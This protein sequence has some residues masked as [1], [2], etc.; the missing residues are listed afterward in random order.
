MSVA[1]LI[2]SRSVLAAKFPANKFFPLFAHKTPRSQRW[3]VF[4]CLPFIFAGIRPGVADTLSM[5]GL[6]LASQSDP[7]CGLGQLSKSLPVEKVAIKSVIDGDTLN[8]VDGRKVRLIGVNAP[9]LLSPRR[10]WEEFYGRKAKAEANSF[11]DRA[12]TA[13]LVRDKQAKDHYG[14]LLAHLF[15]G[16]GESLEAHLLKQGLAWHVAVPPNLHLADCL[17]GLEVEARAQKLGVWRQPA[18]APQTLIEG[19]FQRIR[20]KVEKVTFAKAWWLNFE[21]DLAAVIYP[22]HQHRF[23]KKWLR[24]LEGQVVEVQGWIYSVPKAKKAWRIKLETPHG[25]EK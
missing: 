22:E 7:H 18:V 6:P 19:G 11:F 8:L 20:G 24:R 12:A 9:E 13:Y 10:P 15:N 21:G 3:G 17:A 4:V 23:E 16:K 14:R 25:I 2:A 5:A 1:V